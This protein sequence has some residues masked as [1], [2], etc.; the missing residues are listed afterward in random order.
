MKPT[1]VTG[2]GRGMVKVQRGDR[3]VIA[4]IPDVETAVA[5]LESPLV[6]G[7]DLSL[8][9]S[10]VALSTGEAFTIPS[11]PGVSLP[12]RLARMAGIAQ[13][14]AALVMFTDQPLPRY[15]HLVVIEGPSY[16]SK[17]GH[18]HERAGLWWLVV[19]RL[20][21]MGIEV[22]EMAPTSLKKY[23]TG[24]AIAKKPD[25]RMAWFKRAGVDLPDDNQVDASFLCAAGL[26]HLGHPMFVLPHAQRLALDKVH[27][28][29]TVRSV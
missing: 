8:T 20:V 1:T 27:W 16:N 12:D 26:D 18:A 9:A 2:I 7:I 21:G 3:S 28:P 5:R 15:P 29:P 19:E 13:N 24:T 10:A 6:A 25:M 11:K 14:V 23:A 22:A 17:F 4:S